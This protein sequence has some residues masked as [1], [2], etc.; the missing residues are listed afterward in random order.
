MEKTPDLAEAAKVSLNARGDDGTGWSLAWKVNFWARFKDGDRAYKLYRRLLYPATIKGEKLM[1]QGSGTFSNLFCAHP[2]F[3]LDGN[4]GGTAGMAEILLQS[5]TGVLEILP[6]LPSA[7]EK[8]EVKGLKARGGFEVN[9]KWENQG[10]QQL[11]IVSKNDSKIELKYGQIQKSVQI[12]KDEK[13]IFDKNL[14][15]L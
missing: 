1:G 12:K 9:L 8:G 2:P 14:N 3:Q 15:T 4:M 13:L 10:L 11:E 7:W 6:A 5:H